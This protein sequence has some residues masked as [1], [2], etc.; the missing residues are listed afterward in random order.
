MD[1]IDLQDF[2]D[3]PMFR[4]AVFNARVEEH[5]WARYKGKAVLVGGCSGGLIVPA[6]AY[7]IV[8]TR[9]I[10][11]ADRVYFGDQRSRIPIFDRSKQ[12]K[13]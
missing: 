9:L 4:E 5:D 6:W 10:P 2:T 12:A 11:H 1:K 8:A 7:M 3:G 13:A